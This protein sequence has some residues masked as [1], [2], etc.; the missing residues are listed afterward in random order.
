MSSKITIF[1]YVCSLAPVQVSLAQTS[2]APDKLPVKRVV[3][4]KNGVGYFEHL[5]KVQDRQDVAISF[6]SAQLNDVLKSLTVLDLDGGRITG[7]GYGSQA[8]LDRQLG[9]IRLPIGQRTSLS[10]FLDAIRGARIEL[11][12][13]AQ[14]LTGRLLS[15]E[16]K[17]RA[18]G[19]T[20][21][22]IDYVAVVT[23]N[24]E[25]RTT[26]L[27]PA[28]SVKLLE[29]ELSGKVERY[30]DLSSAT[31]EPDI[32]RMV[33]STEGAGSRSVFLSYISE[34]P[35]WKATYRVVLN[36]K[37]SKT[38]L[39]QGWAVVDNTVGQ[40]WENVQ[41][42]L[43]AG[44][45]Q[46]FIQQLSQPFYTRRPV[47]PLPESLMSQP[48]TFQ[49]TLI[50]GASQLAGIVRDPSGSVVADADVRVYDAIGSL[51][52]QVRTDGMG[53]YSF[54]SLP[55]GAVRLE[56]NVPGFKKLVMT[57]IGISGGRTQRDAV[58][59]IGTSAESVTVTASVPLLNTESSSLASR[60]QQYP[61]MGRSATSRPSG[62]VPTYTTP[63]LDSA[64]SQIQAAALAQ[65]LGDLF[66]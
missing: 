24:G 3:L 63:E 65:S 20:A 11:K 1:L 33:V 4:Y 40:D 64:R 19:G 5:G 36:P 52:G 42:S 29:R 58:L 51:V 15:V 18:S 44:A 14:T 47:V 6:T 50:P 43:V 48:Q 55:L 56:I 31:R 9:E 37:S 41:L 38:P 49:A 32:R 25:V 57:G 34:V 16:R 66:E 62:A 10:E 22:E 54:S 39:L 30:L 2:P 17:T 23:D 7:V 12:S 46:S 26:E 53:A 27:S 61:L 13:G 45:P 28:F 59:E 35:V 21:L 60:N 8:P